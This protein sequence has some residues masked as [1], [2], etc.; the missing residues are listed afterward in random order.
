LHSWYT[1]NSTSGVG[2]VCVRDW[3]RLVFSMFDLL[4]LI[5][6][7]LVVSVNCNVI[8]VHGDVRVNI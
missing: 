3:L 4:T 6:N 7:R 2:L 8:L 1:W 5:I